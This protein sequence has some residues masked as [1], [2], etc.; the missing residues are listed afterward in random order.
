MS[1]NPYI[2]FLTYCL[3]ESLSLPSCIR[4]IDWIKM[5][6]WAESQTVVGVVYQGILR[7]GKSILM[8]FDVLVE[9]VGYA[10][11]LELQNRIVNDRCLRLI[12][13]FSQKG[14]ECCLLKGQ[15]NA[16]MYLFPL[17]RSPG[18]IDLWVRG[19]TVMDTIDFVRENGTDGKAQYL[20]VQYG[21]FDG[22]KAE[23]H[24]RPTFLCNL[25][26]NK[27]IQKWI[28]EH[29]EKQFGND[30]ELP[31][32]MGRITIP[33]WDFNLIFQLSHMYRHVIQSGIGLR[34]IID[35]YYLLK[36][37][38]RVEITDLHQTLHRLGLYQFACSVMW[39]LNQKLGLEKQ[40]L[41]T[42]IDEY[43]GRFLYG[44]IMKG[45]NFG[46]YDEANIKADNRIKKNIQR[47]KRDIR[48]MRHFPSECLWE[49][50]F[51]AYHFFWRM[52]YN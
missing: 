10:N 11:Q 48:M 1:S 17:L 4:D 23:I 12:D 51:R 19:K 45:G 5:L 40:F 15:G 26:N 44:E 41:I 22:V 43:R 49:P 9:W 33:T 16:L 18:D 29:E 39:V 20:D 42:P 21:D 46:K 7:A 28:D 24:Y 27:R 6:R 3:D 36:S 47:I 8:P 32:K 14:F 38:D 35:Y 50:V 25:I 30:V 13:I 34:Q 2:Q 31:E 37:E 52:K